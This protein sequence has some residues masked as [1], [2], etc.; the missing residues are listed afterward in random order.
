M[1]SAIIEVGLGLVMVFFVLSVIVTQVNNLLVNFL[2]LRAENLRAWFHEAITDEA[3]RNEVLT[4]P[5]INI[6][7]AQLTVRRPNIFQRILNRVG[8]WFVARLVPGA[9]NYRSTTKVSYVAPTVFADVLLGVFIKDQGVLTAQSDAEKVY[10]LVL[11]MKDRVEDTPLE[12][13]IETIIANA[14]SFQEAHDKVAAW[15]DNSMNH[16]SAMFK[17]RVQVISFIAGLLISLILNVDALHLARTLWNDPALRQAIVVAAESRSQTGQQSQ[18]GTA[19]SQEQLEE[20]RSTLQSFLDLRLPIG[21]E[22]NPAQ[23]ALQ[24]VSPRNAANFSPVLNPN[25]WLG[26]LALK[27]LG[28]VLT[29]FAIMQGSDFWFNLLGRLTQA[30]TAVAKIT[31]TVSGANP[32]SGAG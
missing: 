3:V 22:I 16:L 4:H 20:L 8:R 2:N 14:Q 30:R 23:D 31:E 17:R 24:L 12:Q 1:G 7:E 21:W 18:P 10:S 19:T 6:V 27:L 13:T 11:A 15:Y 26:F 5:M 9:N 29:T 28:W 32:S 25:D